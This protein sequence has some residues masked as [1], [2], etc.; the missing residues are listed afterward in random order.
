M[1]ILI[2][3]TQYH[4]AAN[5]NVFRWAAIASYWAGAG[6]EVH[7]LCSEHSQRPC[8]ETIQGVQVHR[9]G[10]ATLMDWA[11]NLLKIKRRRSEPG[12]GAGKAGW[13]RSALE[14][15]LNLTWRKLYWPDGSC[16][17]LVPAR[18]R[19]LQL[20]QQNEFDALI[21][22]GTPFTCHLL[23]KACKN[24]F[25]NATWLMDIED[26]FSIAEEFPN[27]NFA[28]YRH[29]N[30]RAEKAAFRCADVIA[31]TNPAVR[32]RYVA[33]FPEPV[34]KMQVIPPLYDPPVPSDFRLP[35]RRSGE[36]RLGY[37][38]SFYHKIRTPQRFLE[39]LEATFRP[40]EALRERL[41]VHFFGYIEPEFIA[42]FDRFRSLSPNI[43]L[44][45]LLRREDAAVAVQQ[46]DA[47]LHIG[48]TTDYH[49]PSKSPEY[50]FS[51]K[52]I[53]NIA[54]CESDAFKEFAGERSALLHLL[55]ETDVSVAA[56][57][58]RDFLL[59]PPVCKQPSDEEMERCG[60][61]AV[62]GKYER[63]ITA[64]SQIFRSK[65]SRPD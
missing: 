23:A 12:A 2:I 43:Q 49:L 65:S 32:R 9:A 7:L 57:Q 22:V 6:H 26:P 53:V 64:G 18:R 25:P 1:R 3:T 5:P 33:V 30:H 13:G 45:G 38:G 21:S 44:H 15:L 41:S 46:M 17:W 60:V 27:N 8:E 61:Q 51:G 34:E 59:D 52:P 42:M 36:I 29:L 63:A 56:G 55:P 16:L 50:L 20:L 58:L 40:S 14:M 62:A 31:L 28:L 19:A 39:L 4:P 11:Y 54:A 37:F 24:R 47:L 48:N 35:P 10:Q